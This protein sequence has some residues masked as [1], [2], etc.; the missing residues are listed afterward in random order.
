MLIRSPLQQETRL[1]LGGSARAAS[2][3]I[4]DGLFVETQ[5]KG[6]SPC[7]VQSASR[8]HGKRVFVGLSP[9]DVGARGS[10]RFAPA[11]TGKDSTFVVRSEVFDGESHVSSYL[12]LVTRGLPYVLPPQAP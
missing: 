6:T 12:A 10:D 2:Q 3:T 4:T 1:C 5:S 7:F 11:L 9:D 8:G